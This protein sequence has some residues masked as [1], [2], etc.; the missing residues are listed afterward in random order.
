MTLLEIKRQLRSGPFAWPGGYPLFAVTSDGAAL[1]F[2]C[3]RKCWRDVVQA[4]LDRA[5]ARSG[6][7]VEAIDANWEDP[8]LHCDHCSTR[9]ESAYAEPE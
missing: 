6:F 7:R 4:H 1:C 9:I 8:T 5:Y 3:V 2:D